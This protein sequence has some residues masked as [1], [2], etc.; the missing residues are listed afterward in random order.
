MNN[1]K[2]F[3][4]NRNELALVTYNAISNNTYEHIYFKDLESKFILLSTKQAKYLGLDSPEEALGKSDF[5]FF[6]SIHAKQAYNDEQR[7]ITTGKPMI[8]T[9]EI[10]TWE[11]KT[12]NYVITSKY[13]LYDDDNN[14]IGTWGHTITL[15]ALQPSPE[16][17]SLKALI[18]EQTDT[19]TPITKIDQLTK[20]KNVK[21]FFDIINLTYQEAMNQLAMPDKDHALIMIDIDGFSTINKDFGH[22]GGDS[23]LIFLANLLEKAV[24]SRDNIYMYGTNSFAILLKITN[25]KEAITLAELILQ[26]AS[27]ESFQHEDIDLHLMLDIGLCT[28]RETLPLG[29]IYDIINLADGRLA[30]AKQ[31][32]PN[33]IIYERE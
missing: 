15:D 17:A 5:D 3:P 4:F 27:L 16:G 22:H 32:G 6:S 8:N 11:N 10:E 18:E 23:A 12:S 1:F 13:P 28:F 29:T 26:K 31:M 14:I 21:A 24:G 7:I 33:A 2:S 19:L 25:I 30:Q 20:L 9:I